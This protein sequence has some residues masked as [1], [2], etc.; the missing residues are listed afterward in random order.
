[1]QH[2]GV[3]G[4][5]STRRPPH[6]LGLGVGLHLGDVLVAAAGEAQV[7]Q[8]LFVDREDTAGGAVL[9][10]H[11]GDGVAVAGRQ[12]GDGRAEEL[13]EL[14]DHTTLAQH[15][16]DGEHQIGGRRTFGELAGDAHADDFRHQHGRRLAEHGRLGL[17]AA[18]APAQHADTVHHRGVAVGAEAAVRVQQAVLL[19]DDAG[20]V[21]DVDL[22]DDAGIRRHRLEV[23]QGFLAPAQEGIALG[24]ALELDLGVEIQRG[25]AAVVVDHHR[26]VDD[27]L[28]GAERVDLGGVAAER[29][30]GVAHGGE[31]DHAGHAGEVL[32]DHA[33]GR[34]VDV[35]GGQLLEI[36]SR[37]S[38]DVLLLDVDAILVA[39]EVLQQHLVRIGQAGDFVLRLQLGEIEERIVLG[40]DGKGGLRFEAVRHGLLAPGRWLDS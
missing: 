23:L 2:V 7:V 40:T 24:V 27:Q 17:D 20:E 35:L 39:E 11:V 18:D 19:E 14:L 38:C 13:D 30:D 4:F 32:Q 15:L 28:D 3:L 21:L 34:E 22:V 12:V 31:I 26:V 36:G 9:R 6:A 37:K 5:C 1:M 10:A 29:L 16:G 33:G 8:G 25:L